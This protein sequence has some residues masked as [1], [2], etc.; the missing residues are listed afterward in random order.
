MLLARVKHIRGWDLAGPD[1]LEHQFGLV[2]RDDL[3]LVTLKEDH[4]HGDVAGF[5]QGRAFDVQIA[6]SGVGADQTIEIARFVFVGFLRKDL[7][8]AQPEQA[9][10][11]LE[12]VAEG[13][14]C[15][16]G[17]SP[18]AA[19][20]NGDLVLVGQPLADQILRR[21]DAVIDIDDTPLA[22]EPFAIRPAVARTAAV[23]HIDKGE[24]TAGEV[25]DAHAEGRVGRA[26][27]P[28][29]AAHDQ[30][31][32]IAL[33]R[34]VV[35][36]GRRVVQRVGD[37]AARGRERNRARHAEVGGVDLRCGRIGD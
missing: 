21:V 31:R 27:W 24:A 8:L 28:A 35:A 30:R 20:L 5:E 29:V 32:P 15:Q 4:W 33:G 25:L 23:V 1:G 10:P 6:L 11:G 12:V 34:A 19:T 7:E 9:G 16:G 26:G 2:G 3:V 22:L 37:R 14:R 18:G 36:A 13:Q 17:V